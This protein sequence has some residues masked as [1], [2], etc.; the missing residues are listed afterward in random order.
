MSDSDQEKAGAPSPPVVRI[1]AR[2]KPALDVTEQEYQLI[3][4]SQ[5]RL[6]VVTG[7]ES[8]S[9]IPLFGLGLPTAAIGIATYS[10]AAPCFPVTERMGTARMKVYP[11]LRKLAGSSLR[12][13]ASAH[14]Q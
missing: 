7:T 11:G 14:S 5:I 2:L 3:Q 9:A 8:A 10:I 1:P 4:R 13:G 12:S 6:W